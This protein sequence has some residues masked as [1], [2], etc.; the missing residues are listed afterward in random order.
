MNDRIAFLKTRINYQNKQKCYY[1]GWC[2]D[3]EKV[4][5]ALAIALDEVEGEMREIIAIKRSHM[6]I[7]NNS[8]LVCCNKIEKFLKL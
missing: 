3:R 8:M 1:N 5:L 4:Y 6:E 7:Y 2:G